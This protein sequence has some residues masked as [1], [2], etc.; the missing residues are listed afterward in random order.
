MLIEQVLSE[1]KSGT[2]SLPRIPSRV[3]TID[4]VLR[5][6]D[7]SMKEILNAISSD[8]SLSTR[9][10]QVAN[11]AWYWSDAKVITLQQAISRLGTHTVHLL[12]MGFGVRDTFKSMD[13]EISSFL[14]KVWG[15]SITVACL[16]AALAK[17]T[18]SLSKDTAFLAGLLHR[19][20]V[21]PVAAFY[22][23]NKSSVQWEP[24]LKE[25][26]EV[27]CS[28]AAS[29]LSSW[30]F[31]LELTMPVSS[32]CSLDCNFLA[33]SYVEVVLR[34][35]FFFSLSRDEFDAAFAKTGLCLQYVDMMPLVGEALE[36][37]RGISGAFS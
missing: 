19:V 9:V 28:L 14:T 2:L 24:L 30:G 34:A 22:E 15:E 5:N 36:V 10:M 27:E 37:Q 13:P 23:K 31:P 20:G 16:A 18:K 21:L 7:S 3:M 1:L 32:S 35:K 4:A 11:S 29:V 25:T 6:D 33:G 12:L 17:R 8:V 26:D